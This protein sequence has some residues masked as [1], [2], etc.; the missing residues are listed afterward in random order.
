M[1]YGIHCI[2]YSIL[3]YNVIYYNAIQSSMI[4]YIYIYTYIT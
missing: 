3:C 4:S 2:S 1:L